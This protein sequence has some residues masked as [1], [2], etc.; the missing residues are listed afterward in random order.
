MWFINTIT[1]SQ[2]ELLNCRLVEVEP[3][4]AVFDHHKQLFIRETPEQAVFP[5]EVGLTPGLNM[6]EL[7]TQP[8]V[9]SQVTSW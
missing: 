2:S 5:Q 8:G 9:Q 3:T 1:C 7:A 6:S 4:P